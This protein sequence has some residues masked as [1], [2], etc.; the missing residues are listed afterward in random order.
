MLTEIARV[1]AQHHGRYGSPRIHQV[2]TTRG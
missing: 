1:F 2:L